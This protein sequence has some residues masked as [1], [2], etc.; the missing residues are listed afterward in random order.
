MLKLNDAKIYIASVYLD[1][2]DTDVVPVNL[3]RLIEFCKTKNIKLIIAI[4]S[5]SHSVLWGKETNNR[6]Q[7]L[8]E[9]ILNYELYL[10]NIGRAPTFW[11]RD[12][13]TVIDITLTL[14]VETQDWKFW[15]RQLCQITTLLHFP[16]TTQT[17][18]QKKYQKL[19]KL[20]G[21]NSSTTRKSI[22]TFH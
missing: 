11:A 15:T 8:E 10:E 1:I 22:L 9:L 21:I 19:L 5:N 6:G 17:Y 2:I 13:S 14:N 16:L 18:Q 3:K 20:T 12:T 7:I 4:D